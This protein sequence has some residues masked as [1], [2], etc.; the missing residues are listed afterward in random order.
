M[1]RSRL[2]I[3]KKERI[4]YKY[5]SFVILAYIIVLSDFHY[6]AED[7]FISFCNRLFPYSTIDIVY[8]WVDGN[9]I[10]WLTEKK[11]WLERYRNIP[12]VA[13][14]SSRFIEHEELRFSL[15]S[16]M[17]NIPWIRKIFILT[18]GQIPYWLNRNHPKIEI[19]THSAV[20]PA[21]SLPTFNS[22]A[23]ETG[24]WNIT[25]L[26]EY[27]IYAN[28]DY[29]F[30]RPLRPSFFFTLQGK[31][32][33]R[34]GVPNVGKRKDTAKLYWKNWNYTSKLFLFQFGKQFLFEPAHT[35]IPYRRSIFRET[36]QIFANEASHTASTKFRSENCIQ[37]A[38]VSF[39][40]L[41]LNEAE[42]VPP[43]TAESKDVKYVVLETPTKMRKTIQLWH[44]SLLCI[45]DDVNTRDDYR[46]QLKPFLQSLYPEPAEWEIDYN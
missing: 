41:Y 46:E 17:R 16:V 12:Q 24:L 22:E 6:K 44:P 13:K 33:I 32:R 21:E 38:L 31:P 30:N 34:I 29:F 36:M 14:D 7:I 26:S 40:E 20:L 37:R 42:L 1:R 19:V 18:N 23:I 35:S 2:R 28:D 5:S 10:N 15:R 39:Y 11:F 25:G 8:T 27:F 4:Y 3:R 43:L 45:N 9:D